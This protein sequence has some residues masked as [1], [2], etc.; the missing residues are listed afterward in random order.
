MGRTDP[1]VFA[2]R[3]SQTGAAGDWLW[4][5]PGSEGKSLCID[6]WE[7]NPCTPVSLETDAHFIYLYLETRHAQQHTGGSKSCWVEFDRLLSHYGLPNF[8]DQ[9]TIFCLWPTRPLLPLLPHPSLI[10]FFLLERGWSYLQG[11]PRYGLGLSKLLNISFEVLEKQQTTPLSL[12]PL[13][14]RTYWEVTAGSLRGRSKFRLYSAKCYVWI[15]GSGPW[16]VGLLTTLQTFP[17]KHRPSGL[18]ADPILS[19]GTKGCSLQADGP[20]RERAQNSRATGLSSFPNS[21]LR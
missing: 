17:P 12:A 6:L 9:R 7:E 20:L 3:K 16:A 10:G 5:W 14:F 18:T 15:W 21:P 19:S 11:T 1:T 2:T 13:E 4:T 8:H